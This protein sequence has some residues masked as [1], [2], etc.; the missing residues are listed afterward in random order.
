M[1]QT[2]NQVLRR[3]HRIGGLLLAGF[4]VFYALTGLLLNHRGSFGYFIARETSISRI[5]VSDPEPLHRFIEN[6]KTMIGRSDDPAVIRIRPDG[7]IEFLYGSHGKV[8]YVIHPQKGTME[9]FE[10]H[11]R[12]PWNWL[13]RLHK[14]FKTGAGWVFFADM[15]A[16]VIL[17][18]TLTGL[19]LVRRRSLDAGLIFA[20]GLLLA[21]AAFLA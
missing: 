16:I 6:C 17:L 15:V 2:T 4:L 7:S 10:K 1:Q 20:G 12:Q 14:A 11:P 19:L 5:P 21:L 3:I 18:V 13:N 8:T 9:R